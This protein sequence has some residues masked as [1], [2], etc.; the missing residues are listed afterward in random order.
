MAPTDNPYANALDGLVLDDPVAAFFDFCRERERVRERRER[1]EAAPWSE[2]P[3]F[4]RARFLNVF[5][6]DDRGTKAIDRFVAPRREDLPGLVQAVFFARWCNRQST[7]DTLSVAD[8]ADPEGLRARLE[9]LPEQPWCN[10]TAYPVEPVRWEGTLYSRLDTATRLFAELG[11][12]LTEVLLDADGTIAG[13]TA[14]VNRLLGMVNDFP[15]FMAVADLA[16]FRPD[17]VDPNSP[18]PTGIGAVA[19]LDRLQD[20]LGLPDHHSTCDAIIALQPSYWPEARRALRPIDVEYLSCECRKYYSYVNG[21][22]RFEGRNL[23]SPGK[24]PRLTV[25]WPEET[26]RPPVQTRIHV[27]AGGPCSGKT[28]LLQALKESGYRVVEETSRVLLE[29]GI[30]AGRSA[31][32]LRADPIQW[33][34]RVME[35]DHQLFDGLPEDELIFTDTS[36]IEDLVFGERAGLEAGPGLVA[37]LHRKRYARVFFLEPVDYES[38][39]ARLESQA[40]A[41][42]IGDEVRSRYE[43]YGYEV[44]SVPKAPV[45][46]RLARVLSGVV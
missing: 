2:D 21:T 13:A 42:R 27:L 14:A 44:V 43:E 12:L 22:K 19:F 15:I 25:D 28:T 17:C 8:L 46:E 5:A 34:R 3:I 26:P 9:A 30:A 24:V 29:E 11:P 6:E 1:G 35:L 7:L 23:F 32:E 36:F 39:T 4:Q 40:L 33:Q 41:R 37:W 45:S 38:G 16:R 31:A 20:H 18:V 10:V